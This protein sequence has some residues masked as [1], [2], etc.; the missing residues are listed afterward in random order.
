MNAAFQAR[1]KSKLTLG[2]A[3][4]L[5]AAASTVCLA[6]GPPTIMI[7]RGAGQQTTYGSAFPAPLVVWVT[8]PVTERSVSGL[9]VDF[10]PGAGVLLSSSYAI[11]DELGLASV[12]ANGIAACTS[13][14]TAEISGFPD[15]R[16]SFDDL[17]VEKA[18]LTVVP[19]DLASRLAT[20]VPAITTYTITGFVNGDTE[21]TAQITGLPELTTTASDHSPHANYAIKGGI[22]SLSSPN[23]TFVAGFGTLA[24]LEGAGSDSAHSQPWEASSGISARSDEVVVR[25]ALASQMAG[26]TVPQPEFVAGLHGQSGVFVVNAIWPEAKSV[27]QSTQPL[28]TRSALPA[29]AAAA[30]NALDAPVR[31]VEMPKMATVSASASQLSDT[32]SALAPLPVALQKGSEVP[33]RA[34]LLTDQAPSATPRSALAGS[35]I[36]K[37]F[38][39][40][41]AN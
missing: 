32:R 28:D 15:A 39:S 33:V 9:R 38:N 16:V 25:S 35:S 21:E 19:G 40:P 30:A 27:P 12:T 34:V 8:D 11:T 18:T 17:V 13:R 23:Y 7:L 5:L 29:V 6:S 37:A 22:G 31:A 10:T 14:V 3:A 20:S 2:C 26:L 4:S 24:I 1:L 36:R 41:G